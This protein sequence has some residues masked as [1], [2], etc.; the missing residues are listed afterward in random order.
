MFWMKPS[1]KKLR[2]YKTIRLAGM[3]FIIKK[4]NPIVDFPQG[5]MPQIFTSFISRRKVEGEQPVS[6]AIL[7]K[8]QEDMKNVIQAGL[9]EPKLSDE[10]IHIDDI[11]ADSVLALKLYT[12]IITHS[13]NRFRG[14]KGVFFSRKIRRTFYSEWQKNMEKLQA[15]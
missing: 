1:K 4:I 10:G 11:L 6:E 8:N 15:K 13:L 7:R 12:E 5:K 3:K 2:Q 14:L 9:I